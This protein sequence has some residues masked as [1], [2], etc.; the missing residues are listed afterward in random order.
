MKIRFVH[1]SPIVGGLALATERLAT[2]LTERGHRCDLLVPAA[3]HSDRAGPVPQVA[4]DELTLTAVKDASGLTRALADGEPDLLVVGTGR[5]D[6]LEAA[7]AV[8]PTLLH[9]HMHWAVCP[10]AGRYWNRVGLECSVKAGWKCAALR[11]LLGCSGRQRAFDPRF[12]RNQQRLI[13]LLAT[14]AIGAIAISHRQAELLVDHGVSERSISVIPNLGMRMT[15]QQLAAAAAGTPEDER[16][17]VCFFGRL[18]KEKGAQH[19]PELAALIGDVPLRVF[20]EGYLDESLRLGPSLRGHVSQT[21]VAGVLQ[22]ARATVFPSQWPEPGGIVGID[23]Q[24]SGCPLAAFAAGAALDWPD[25]ELFAPGQVASMAEW[26]AQQPPMTEPRAPELIAARQSSY[27][28][29]VVGGASRDLE[30]FA[31]SGFFAPASG[32]RVREAIE[33]S[34]DDR[35]RPST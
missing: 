2:A 6:I 34:T 20:G 30:H 18:S 17:A 22:W 21:R 26:V 3:H 29:H 23:A 4:T 31:T 15:P 7:L 27:W 13:E 16:S 14:G 12:V 35:A 25:A 28:N 32:N 33:V 5:V 19:L 10:D 8:A 11:P 24:L 1:D 9:S